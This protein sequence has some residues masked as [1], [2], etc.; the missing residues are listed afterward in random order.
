[1]KKIL[2]VSIA[3]YNVEDYI[4][5]CLMPFTQNGVSERCEVLIIDDGGTDSTREIA[6]R[7]ERELPDTFK[8]IHKENGGWGSTVNTG[9]RL[10]HGKYFKQLDGDDFFNP[11]SLKEFLDALE[12]LNSDVV[13][14]PF[15]TFISDTKEVVKS[16]D[17]ITQFCVVPYHEYFL[18]ELKRENIAMHQ[19]TFRTSMLQA[20]DISL[21]EHTFYTDVELVIKA[22]CNSNTVSFVP[23]TVYCYRT[24]R[25]GQSMSAEGM[26]KHYKEHEK[27]LFGIAEYLRKSKTSPGYTLSEKRLNTMVRWQY[28]FYTNLI[29]NYKHLKEIRAFDRRL[30][31][32]YPEFY[33]QSSKKVKLMRATG[34]LTYYPMCRIEAKR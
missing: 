30:K 32:E 2:T 23:M 15:I 16:N 25:D 14:S 26:R 20:N 22:L 31:K 5:E 34:F 27:V 1:M 29:P 18:S 33:Y 7:F 12:K 6:E 3:A 10:A 11:N 19:C 24:A 9:I 17:P 4:E 28:L 8:V 21:L 13:L